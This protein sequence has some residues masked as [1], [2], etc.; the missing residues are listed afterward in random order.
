MTEPERKD[1]HATK[2]RMLMNRLE[3]NVARLAPWAQREQTTCYRVFD[4]D[5]PELPL[6]IDWYDGR[7]HIA[8][9][10]PRHGLVGHDHDAFIDALVDA[11]AKA[12]HVD[13]AAVFLK[14]REVGVGGAQYEKVAATQERCAVLESGHTFLV[15][16]RDYLDT[17]LFLD[18]RVT[19]RR[20]QTESAGKRVLNLFGYTGSFSVYAGRGGATSTTT[21]DLSPSYCA[22]AK[23]NLE[24]NGLTG[25][26]HRVVPADVFAY[27]ECVSERFDLIVL[28]P[29]T[30]SKSKRATRDLDVQRDHA[31]LLRAA[32]S[33]L[34]RGGILYFSTS[35][36][37]FALDE[38][39][40]VD[41]E[42]EELTPASIPQDFR[43]K[44]IHRC[45]RIVKR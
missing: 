27:L 41:V 36:R 23:D 4:R 44:S 2:A 5:I 25:E 45:W 3:K 29:P 38:Q 1:A 37:G 14:R 39:R 15:N 31:G 43:N 6:A 17:G 7:L 42:R 9:Y 34:T 16:L 32:T 10:A 11:A 35:F 18:H 20:V 21:V 30:I 19:R 22:W 26:A 12:L 33:K 28:D 13:R 40:L 24:A 8:E